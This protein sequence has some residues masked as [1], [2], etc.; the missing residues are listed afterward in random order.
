MS[1]KVTMTLPLVVNTEV[2]R[3]VEFPIFLHDK[4]R[5]KWYAVILEDASS[6]YVPYH[7]VEVCNYKFYKKIYDNYGTE[8]EVAPIL[9]K[10]DTGDAVEISRDEF[11]SAYNEAIQ[12][13]L[14]LIDKI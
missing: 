4:G 3:E 10:Q 9:A 6:K 12:S 8:R 13:Y 5:E 7:I 11:L 14:T 1:N 2:T